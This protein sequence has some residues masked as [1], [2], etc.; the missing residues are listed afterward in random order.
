MPGFLDDTYSAAFNWGR[1]FLKAVDLS[2]E[3]VSS[4]TMSPSIR[5]V[6]RQDI[7]CM[8]MPIEIFFSLIYP[9]S[10]YLNDHGKFLP[11]LLIDFGFYNP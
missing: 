4:K 10:V 6:I 11:F 1:I 8:S 7:L 5:V 2:I 3:I 9:L